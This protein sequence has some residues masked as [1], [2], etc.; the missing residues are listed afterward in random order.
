MYLNGTNNLRSDN[1][2][3]SILDGMPLSL[4]D[5]TLTLGTVSLGSGNCEH[6]MRDDARQARFPTAA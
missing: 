6:T 3:I 1:A 2:Q 4:R 5:A